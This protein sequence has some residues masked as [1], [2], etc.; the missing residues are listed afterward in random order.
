MMMELRVLHY[1]LTVARKQSFSKAAEELHITQPTLSR[2]IKELEEMYHVTLF[3]RDT[4][5]VELTEEGLL[6]KK[7]AEEILRLVRV[8]S[9]ELT[10]PEVLAGD[11]HIACPE[12][13]SMR[14]V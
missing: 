14:I 10:N 5:H 4:R 11:I 8:T 12:S 2:Q 13:N 9:E 3:K 7:R 6:L 1:F